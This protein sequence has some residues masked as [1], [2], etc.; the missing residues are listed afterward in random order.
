[1]KIKN[2][3][4]AFIFLIAVILSMTVGLAAAQDLTVHFIAVGHGDAIFIEFPEGQ[5]MLIDGGAEEMGRSVCNYMEDRGYDK[6][7]YVVLT[8][9]H[10]DHIGGLIKVVEDFEI[11]EIWMYPY[12]D[13]YDLV[14][15]FQHAYKSRSIRALEVTR[16]NTFNIDEV[17]I[18]IINPPFGSSLDRLNGPNG[19]SIAM[20]MTYGETS[21]LLMADVDDDTDQIIAR[22]NGDFL[23]AD[24][25]K[26]GH[27]GSG[28]S[29]SEVFL[30]TVSANIAVVSTGPSEWGYPSERTMARIAQYCGKVFRTDE[31]GTIVI[32]SDGKNI[33]V[34]QPE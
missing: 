27:H 17:K 28:G 3:Y 14:Q 20:K 34:I 33:E 31:A 16:G 8:H 30:K 18:R 24:V 7:D 9:T 32:E 22:E 25:L 2:Y 12:M 1:M 6:I 11:G 15:Q 26:C 29:S 13:D 21:F 23:R 10:P 19:A 5:T 4:L